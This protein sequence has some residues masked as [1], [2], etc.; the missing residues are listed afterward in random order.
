MVHVLRSSKNATSRKSL[1]R[2]RYRDAA[3]S[4]FRRLQ[5]EALEPRRVLST[6]V[7][8]P[9]FLVNTYTASSENNP[10]IDM[11]SNGNSVVVWQGRQGPIAVYGQQYDATGT[12]VGNEFLVSPPIGGGDQFDPDVAVD[13][14]GNFVAVWDGAGIHGQRFDSTGNQLGATF[15]VNSNS[16]DL[17]SSPAVAMS[18]DGD[19]VVVWVDATSGL[20]RVF[21]QRYSAAGDKEG[22]IVRIDTTEGNNGYPAVAMNGNGDFVVAWTVQDSERTD[23]YGQRFDASGAKS[24]DE[25]RI[26]SSAF[27]RNDAPSIAA[28]VNGNFVVSWLSGFGTSTPGR[29]VGQRYAASG[30]KLGTEF[31]ADSSNW[32]GLDAPSIAL[33]P[34]HGEFLIVWTGVVDADADVYGQRFDS[35]GV[36]L[37]DEFRINSY[38]TSTQ[39]GPAVAADLDGDYVTVWN[40]WGQDGSGNG[41][42]GKMLQ[43]NYA[44]DG[45]RGP[46]HGERGRRRH[47]RQ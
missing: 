1:K 15:L 38:T 17:V 24:G 3:A 26:S 43:S 30:T 19:S 33:D 8:G 25:F 35:S 45:G 2:R 46:C 32:N 37:G 21:G 42:F 5:L 39:R 44:P 14:S 4:R 22:D 36:K 9:E 7:A 10:A 6:L 31:F 29:I 27:P 23:V 18:S 40:S 47:G 16:W 11:D 41:V 13:A 28:D 12:P 34:N 20:G